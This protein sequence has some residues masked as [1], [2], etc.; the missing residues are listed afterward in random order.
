[1]VAD[2]LAEQAGAA[3]AAGAGREKEPPHA[4]R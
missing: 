3:L 2:T 4:D 1:M